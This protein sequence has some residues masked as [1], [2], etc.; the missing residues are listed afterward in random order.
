MKNAEATIR[1]S[2]KAPP[3]LSQTCTVGAHIHAL[4][5]LSNG[6]SVPYAATLRAVLHEGNP[7]PRQEKMQDRKH[8]GFIRNEFGGYFCA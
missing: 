5:A 6:Q 3:F 7:E 2:Q 1:L 8:A 4:Q